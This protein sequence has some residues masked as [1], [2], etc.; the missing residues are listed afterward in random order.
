MNYTKITFRFA[1]D[2]E[3]F[4]ADIVA[5]QLGE[6]GFDSFEETTLGFVGYC[7]TNIFDEEEM[8]RAIDSLPCHVSYRYRIEPM[9]DKDWN[10]TWE[11]NSFEPIDI[12]HRC[13]IFGTKDSGKFNCEY[14]ILINPKQAFGSGHHQTT[15]LIIRYLLD[16]DLKDK[17][18]LDMGCG[19]GVLGIVA[20]K[21]GTKKVVAIDIDEWSQRNAQENAALNGVSDRIE[22][23][24]GSAEQIGSDHFD[25]ILANINRNILLEQMAFYAAALNAGGALI[26]SGFYSTDVPI[27]QKKAEEVGLKLIAQKSDDDWTMCVLEKYSSH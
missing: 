7:P 24:L 4:V 13:I 17:A 23:R 25:L 26:I 14:P 27:L 1:D 19:T 2:A 6:I 8:T 21:R 12:D 9:E 10:E 22:V 15:R 3:P 5:A 16:F 20:A 11:Q 18:V